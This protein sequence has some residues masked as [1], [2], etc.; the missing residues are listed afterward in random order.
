M[1]SFDLKSLRYEYPDEALKLTRT[2]PEELRFLAH[3]GAK[4]RYPRGVPERVTAQIDYELAII[5][6]LEYEPYFLTVHHIVKGARAKG[7]LCQGRGSAANSIVCFCIGVTEVSPERAGL[8]FERFISPDRREPPDIDIDFEHERREE[9]IQY[10]YD[11]YG[12]DNAALAA[13]VI[14][15][16]ARSSAREVGKAFGLS[17]DAVAALSGSVWSY[18][19]G[20]LGERE[21]AAAG[22][23]VTDRTTAD[24]LNY[25]AEL[26]GFPRHLSQHVG[27][28]VITRGR[29]DEV[30]PILN[31]AM[32]GRTIVEWDKDDLDELGILKID[33]LALG[34]LS[35]L[36]RA[37]DLWKST[38]ASG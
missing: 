21:A 13:T 32:E 29:I 8:L 26:S 30:V 1:L 6:E 28:F 15:Y 24:V 34:M 38:T 35:C 17:E 27:G 22:L 3:E 16:R 19:S 37:F 33:I 10:I 5:R 9:V 11:H 7:I 12:R 31:S 20:D 36:R 23:A 18:S 2:P 25:A 4:W 14:T